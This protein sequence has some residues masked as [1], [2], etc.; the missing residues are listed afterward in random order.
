M[1]ASFEPRLSQPQVLASR[2]AR[3]NAER[4]YHITKEDLPLCCPL[5][6]MALWDSHPRVYLPLDE[7]GFAKC[8]YCAAEFRLK[9]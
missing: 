3:A 9:H 6:R 2:S 7:N 5:P 1:S 8:P 4:E